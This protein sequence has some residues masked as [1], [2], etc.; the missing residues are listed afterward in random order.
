MEPPTP[1]ED[2]NLGSSS[3]DSQNPPAHGENITYNC[4]NTGYNRFESDFTLDKLT[5]ICLPNNQF[6]LESWPRCVDGKIICQFS[7]NTEWLF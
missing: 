3:F 2:S 6:S 7:E 5:L 1:P 4:A